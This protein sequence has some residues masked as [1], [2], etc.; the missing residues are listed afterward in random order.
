MNFF[1]FSEGNEE[2][3]TCRSV[4]SESN[5]LIIFDMITSAPSITIGN[6]IRGLK[7]HLMMEKGEISQI[8]G[9]SGEVEMITYQVYYW[10]I[11]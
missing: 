8:W 5:P 11:N 4:I 10:N 9:K 6:N 1:H 7:L 2:R 3:M